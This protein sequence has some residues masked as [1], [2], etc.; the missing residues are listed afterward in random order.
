[1]LHE[2]IHSWYCAWLNKFTSTWFWPGFFTR[3]QRVL[4]SSIRLSVC[5]FITLCFLRI[6]W[7]IPWKEWPRI[8]YAGVFRWLTPQSLLTPMGIIGISRVHLSVNLSVSL[9]CGICR[10]IDLKEWPQFTMPLYPVDLPPAAIDTDEY[11]CH[12]MCS[13]ICPSLRGFQFGYLPTNRLEEMAYKSICSCIQM[14]YPRS[15]SMPMW[16]FCIRP[17]VPGLGLGSDWVGVGFVFGFV[18]PSLGYTGR[19]YLLSLLVQH[20]R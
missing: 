12:F 8:W 18:L 14:S 5:S 6:S 15:A 4:V 13:S 9:G 11:Y 16:I 1:M 10:H 2:K 19:G 17:V 7:Q 3:L 20:S